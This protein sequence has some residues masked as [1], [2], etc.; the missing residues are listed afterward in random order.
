MIQLRQRFLYVILI[1]LTIFLFGI[2]NQALS[3][4]ST[5]SQS[6]VTFYV[7]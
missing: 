6:K 3:N 1:I 4:S 7:H 5:N 2:A